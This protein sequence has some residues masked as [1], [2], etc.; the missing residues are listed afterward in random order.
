[1]PAPIAYTLGRKAPDAPPDAFFTKEMRSVGI[2]IERSAA[3]PA[4]LVTR[5]ANAL[6]LHP[7]ASAAT[8]SSSSTDALAV[9]NALT[10][11]V[12]LGKP[13][14]TGPP[15]SWN[16]VAAD[17]QGTVW[18]TPEGVRWEG[19]EGGQVQ[20]HED[21][22]TARLW[23]ENPRTPA[24]RHAVASGLRHALTGALARLGWTPLHAAALRPPP[25]ADSGASVLLVGPSGSGK[26]TLTAGLLQRGWRCVSDDQV[27]LAPSDHAAPR[28]GR[29]SPTLRLC[30]DAWTRLGFQKAAFSSS[31]TRVPLADGAPSDPAQKWSVPLGTLDDHAPARTAAWAVPRRV[32]RVGIADT[33]TSRLV[34]CRA[35]RLLPTL[36]SQSL[37]PSVLPTAVATA[38][39]QRLGALLRHADGFELTAGHDL[40]EA[41]GRLADLLTAARTPS[42]ASTA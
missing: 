12:R 40:Y 41:P 1:M 6:A 26:S 27:A 14:T 25:N 9:T 28:V 31:A 24:G 21:R 16:C 33:P 15:S 38:Q 20:W 4:A 2:W 8:S 18:R 17:A 39:T 11:E 30:P 13:H 5:A 42:R 22:G 37:P 36:L 35:A 19:D 32:I 10:I 3:V 29:L 34:P 7:H 23:V